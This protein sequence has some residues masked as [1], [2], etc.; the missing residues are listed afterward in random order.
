M[1]LES[2]AGARSWRPFQAMVR[3][4]HF[5]QRIMGSLWKVV[6]LWACPELNCKK[7]LQATLKDYGLQDSECG[8]GKPSWK[9]VALAGGD[10]SSGQGGGSRG[11]VKW[12]LLVSQD[13]LVDW[14]WDW[15]ERSGT[16]DACVFDLGSRGN[17]NIKMGKTYFFPTS[18]IS[19][20]VYC[21]FIE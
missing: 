8:S 4:V 9:A 7:L 12:V 3:S 11:N 18:F 20:E 5:I 1:R 19:I 13:L 6:N 2:G 16:E 17:G 14:M 15:R 10:G 21:H